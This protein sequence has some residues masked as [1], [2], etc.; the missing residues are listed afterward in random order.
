MVPFSIIEECKNEINTLRKTKDGEDQNQQLRSFLVVIE[1]AYN[2]WEGLGKQPGYEILLHIYFASKV[3]EKL[4]DKNDMKLLVGQNLKKIEIDGKYFEAF[5]KFKED[6]PSSKI[7]S[8]YIRP[9][10]CLIQKPRILQIIE[11]KGIGNCHEDL[12]ELEYMAEAVK[13]LE[14]NQLNKIEYAELFFSI[15]NESISDDKDAENYISKKNPRICKKIS[16]G[17]NLEAWCCLKLKN[18]KY[19]KIFLVN[20]RLGC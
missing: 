6:N 4:S 16:D 3:K 18:D 14:E 15:D 8:K 12:K 20:L 10:I 11:L 19:L 5:E 1:E 9:D 17:R 2:L 7:P 13:Y